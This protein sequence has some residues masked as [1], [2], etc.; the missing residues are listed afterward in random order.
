M[1]PVFSDNTSNSTYPSDTVIFTGVSGSIDVGKPVTLSDSTTFALS[2][3]GDD[4]D[5]FIYSVD[6]IFDD[7]TVVG[8][9]VRQPLLRKKVVNAGATQLDIK[10]TVVADDQVTAGTAGLPQVKA[11]TGG[12]RVI[13]LLGGTGLTDEELIIEKV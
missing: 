9:V 4:F 8:T 2:E 10:D 12:W 7:G 5:G 13:E 11:G 6:D 3:A 1:L